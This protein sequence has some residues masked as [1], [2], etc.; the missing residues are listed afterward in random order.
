MKHSQK[1]YCKETIM[2]RLGTVDTLEEEPE[3]VSYAELNDYDY[4]D[5]ADVSDKEITNVSEK[6]LKLGILKRGIL[7]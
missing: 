7:L 5:Y 6:V 2:K 4:D 1:T 3:K